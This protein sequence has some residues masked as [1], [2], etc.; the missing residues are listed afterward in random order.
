MVHNSLL[1]GMNDRQ[2]ARWAGTR[3]ECGFRGDKCKPF[4]NSGGG[5]L[6]GRQGTRTGGGVPRVLSRLI[7]DRIS[8]DVV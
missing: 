4:A 1:G 7:S 6:N 8:T 5:M 3:Q 2:R